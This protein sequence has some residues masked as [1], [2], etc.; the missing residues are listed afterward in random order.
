MTTARAREAEKP[1][2]LGNTSALPGM[3]V[4]EMSVVP[5]KIGSLYVPESTQDEIRSDRGTVVSAGARYDGRIE[6][7][8]GWT[9]P[10]AE[11]CTGDEVLCLWG[12]GKVVSGFGWDDERPGTE[13]RFFGVAGGRTCLHDS[14]RVR[15]ERSVLGKF[16]GGSSMEDFMPVGDNVKVRLTPQTGLIERVHVRFDPVCEVLA[17]GARCVNVVPGDKVVVNRESLLLLDG[18]DDAVIPEGEVYAKYEC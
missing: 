4:V 10:S 11:L 7:R 5:G 9:D 6:G 17:V 14:E 3:L 13:T 16:V 1:K 2:P 12:M 15:F 18:T 8:K